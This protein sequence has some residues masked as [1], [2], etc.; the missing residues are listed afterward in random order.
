M[1]RRAGPDLG[2][3]WLEALKGGQLDVGQR[4]GEGSW[5]C[6]KAEGATGVSDE[7]FQDWVQHHQSTLG[8][9]GSAQRGLYQSTGRPESYS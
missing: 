2:L 6:V 5:L 7:G 1:L 9:M 4:Q 8:S 3:F